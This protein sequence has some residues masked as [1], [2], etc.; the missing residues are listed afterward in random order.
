M[1]STDDSIEAR[2][3][4]A[5][6]DEVMQRLQLLLQPLLEP[7]PVAPVP[8]APHTTEHDGKLFLTVTE[9]AELLGVHRDTLLRYEQ[10]N[11][12]PARSTMGGRTGW[13]RTEID[14]FLAGLPRRPKLR[15]GRFGSAN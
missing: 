4:R 8:A 11:R 15:Q 5:A 14:A 3:A 6:A 7:A 2:I 13:S 12:L 1:R 10:Q 9:T